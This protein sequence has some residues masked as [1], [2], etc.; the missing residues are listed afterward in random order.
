MEA[1]TTASDASVLDASLNA[2]CVRARSL[3]ALLRADD[4]VARPQ[5]HSEP[6]THTLVGRRLSLPNPG[7]LPD[8]W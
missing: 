7:F 1:A 8:L 6:H 4:V 5:A 3:N 2:S